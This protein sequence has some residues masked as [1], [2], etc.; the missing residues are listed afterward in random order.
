MH[1]TTTMELLLKNPLEKDLCMEV[2][3][4][5]SDDLHGDSKI[6]IPPSESIVYQLN[7]EPTIIGQSK[8]R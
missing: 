3:I 8:A 6:C 4:N 7:F 1:E 5:G 2:V